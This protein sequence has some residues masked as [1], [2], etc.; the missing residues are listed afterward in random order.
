VRAS[1]AVAATPLLDAAGNEV[2]SIQVDQDIAKD[3]GCSLLI[4]PVGESVV[5]STYTDPNV[6]FLAG[7][8][9]YIAFLNNASQPC[10]LDSTKFITLTYKNLETATI[11]CA[12]YIGNATVALSGTNACKVS[13]TT[14]VAGVAP[15]FGTAAP[16]A[17]PVPA[18]AAPAPSASAAPSNPSVAPS[19]PTGSGSVAPSGPAT[20]SSASGGGSDTTSPSVAVSVSSLLIAVVLSLIALLI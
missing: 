16:T 12:A 15:Y 14:L 10:N 4:S 8:T 19:G 2:V 1:A 13:G 7:P 3:D 6:G 17:F 9:V 18:T 11:A 5:D 20:S